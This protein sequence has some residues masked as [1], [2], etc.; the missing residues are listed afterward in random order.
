MDIK[1]TVKRLS[2]V[3]GL[4]GCEQRAAETCRALLQPYMD[5]VTID[6]FYNVVGIKRCG[7]K[8]APVLMFDAHIDQVGFYVQGYAGD[9][10]WYVGEIGMDI[11]LAPSLPVRVLTRGGAEVPGVLT[12]GDGE[13]GDKVVPLEKLYLDVGLAEEESK[14]LIH[15]N[16]PVVCDSVPYEM[17]DAMVC[18]SA[19]DDRGCFTALLRMAELLQDASLEADII[20]QGATRE[21]VGGPSAAVSAAGIQPDLFFAVDVCHA[22]TADN[23]KDEELHKGPSIA[24]QG[25]CDTRAE[26]RLFELAKEYGIPH[27]NYLIS[28]ISGTNAGE[29]RPAGTGIP[30]AVVSLPIRYMHAPYEVVSVNDIEGLAQLC[31]RFACG[32]KGFGEEV[33][34]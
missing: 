23:K 9:G 31:Y 7:K 16:D 24:R 8:N 1:E 5:S 13:P 12:A 10:L 22:R 27:Q 29:V 11:R 17:G 34:A 6:S 33:R 25:T 4:S 20:I 28:Y 19:V 14:A 18:A 2:R 3:H 32:F 30:C 21:E 26:K 15:P